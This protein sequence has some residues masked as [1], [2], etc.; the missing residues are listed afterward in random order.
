[1]V[2]SAIGSLFIAPNG[3]ITPAT[4]LIMIGLPVLW[5]GRVWLGLGIVALGF[6]SALRDAMKELKET[7]KIEIRYSILDPV[8][9]IAE[10]E[11]LSQSSTT[12]LTKEKLE[13]NTKRAHCMA[14]LGALAK[15]YHREQ[16]H[17]PN[18]PLLCQQGAYISLRLFP[19]DDEILAGAISLLALVAKKPSVRRRNKYQADEYGLDVPIGALQKS[20]GRAKREEDESREEV[21]AEIQRKGALYL[22]ALAD[23]DTEFDLPV[24]ITEE[25]GLDVI[26]DAANWF[27]FHEGVANWALWAMFIIC[28]ENVRNKIQF[29]RLGGITTVCQ[30]MKNNPSSLEV[31]R[32][33][34]AILFDL[35]RE[36]NETES[37]KWDH[38]EVR[39]ASL[40]AGLH[41][42]ALNAMKEFPD[43]M[44]IIMMGQ[45]M[46]IG[47]GYRGDIPQAQQL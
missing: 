37:I 17:S 21:L 44:D 27:R 41:E 46:L 6:L 30:L 3:G 42:V 25:D 39:K 18:L 40:G 14:S 47:T 7:D 11:Q 15:K 4:F 12:S 5:T 19:E 24:K 26:L 35:L 33:G 22:G 1:M 45:E 34:I 10:V 32:H 8:D 20:L 23:G 9:I 13:E 43:S 36:G 16:G 28:Y 38:L 31:N 29:V 2:E